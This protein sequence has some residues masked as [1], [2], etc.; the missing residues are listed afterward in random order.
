MDLGGT[1]CAALLTVCAARDY[2]ADM[3]SAVPHHPMSAVRARVAACVPI[4]HEHVQLDVVLP[5]FP[6]SV[7][8][9]F[10]QL[11]CRADDE[12]A[13]GVLEWHE[14]CLPT[15]S[16][17]D[18]TERS[19]YLRR[20]FSLADHW[21]DTD[22]ATHLGVIS[23]SVGSG[24][25]WL[26]RLRPGDTLN[27]TGPLGRG[28]EIPGDARPLVLV[29]GGV[30]IPPLLYLARRLHEL[31]RTDVTVILGARERNLLPVGLRQEPARDG[32]PTDCVAL[33]G[34][35]H[36]AATVTSDDGSIGLRGLVTDALGQWHARRRLTGPA[37]VYACGPAG[38]LRALAAQTRELG[39][40]CQLCIERNMGCGLGTCLSC[41]VRARDA[42]QP[43]GWRWALTC[44][45]G[46]VF[47]R[48]LLLDYAPTSAA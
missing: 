28:F 46:P 33:P 6:A 32:T 8:G 42:T 40:G 19:A 37:M 25:R 41:V 43:A 2:H 44:Q 16:S 26:A 3:S 27:L 22:G 24:T 15:W 38:M 10:V 39:L 31:G 48:D 23:H 13:P 36:C 21:R 35:A 11:L 9:Q 30:G 5:V 12:V 20:P 34:A 7:P 18:V 17:P 14:D 29:G 4:C 47:E 45:E 1:R